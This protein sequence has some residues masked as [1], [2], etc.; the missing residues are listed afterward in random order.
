MDDTI[1]VG[2][3]KGVMRFP[4]AGGAPEF[5]TTV[6]HLDPPPATWSTCAGKT[7]FAAPFDREDSP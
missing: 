6:I 5:L 7:L 1:L 4:A 2:S 3:T